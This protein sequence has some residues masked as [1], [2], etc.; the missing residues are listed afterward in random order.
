[1]K[2]FAPRI[3]VNIINKL[4][5]AEN[6]VDRGPL[7]GPLAIFLVAIRYVRFTSIVLINS[8][9]CI[10]HNSADRWQPR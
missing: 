4:Q 5:G 10:D 3:D 2:K 6:Q 9:F 8:N 7:A 1:M